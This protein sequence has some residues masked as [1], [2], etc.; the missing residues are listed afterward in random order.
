MRAAEGL[1]AHALSVTGTFTGEIQAH[2]LTARAG[3]ARQEP[4]PTNKS[5]DA[6]LR[7]VGHGHVPV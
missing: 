3:L 5:A 4:R 6:S 1:R 7:T 2:A